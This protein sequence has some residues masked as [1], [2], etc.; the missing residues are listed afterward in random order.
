MKK[1]FYL[2]IILF[3]FV[4]C[5]PKQDE[6][7]RIIEDGVEVVINHLEPYKIKGELYTL[8]LDEEFTIDTER[9]KIA[10]IG[11]TD[12]NGF[13]IDSEGNFYFFQEREYD[14]NLIYKFDKT[15]NFVNTFGK[16]GQGPGEIQYP[17]FSGVDK[18][19]EI[20]IQDSNRP[21]FFVFDRNGNLTKEVDLGSEIESSLVFCP[22]ENN[23]YLSFGLVLDQQDRHFYDIAQLYN[24]KF[25]VLKELDKCDYG[26]VLSLTPSFKGTPRIF[27]CRISDEMIYLGHE[28]RGY[29]ILVYDTE[30]NLVRKI[31][32]EYVPTEVPDEFKENWYR[33]MGRYKDKLYFP[34]KMPPFH[35]FF[36]DDEGR[37]YVKTYEK[38]NKEDEYMHDIFNS[39]GIFIARVSLPGYGNWI[40]PQISLNRAKIKDNRFYCIRKKESGYKELVVYKMNG[41]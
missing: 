24:S 25:E 28:N 14:E 38:G 7:E 8:T 6:V 15:G 32:K 4:C 31:R 26:P 35:Y 13:D 33:S 17:I 30:G 40:L 12:I 34:N 18:K 19:N 11:L 3:L 5:G 9:D 10:E 16:R 23:N 41:E 1:L 36:F 20:L 2:I 39:E 27:M 22:L 37:L 21:R 29:E